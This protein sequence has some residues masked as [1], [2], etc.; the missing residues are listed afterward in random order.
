[1]TTENPPHPPF[2]NAVDGAAPRERV[3][4]YNA[5]QLRLDTWNHLQVTCNWLREFARTGRQYDEPRALVAADLDTLRSLEAYWAFPGW[6]VVEE[7]TRLYERRDYEGLARNVTEVARLLVGDAYRSRGIAMN[8]RHHGS[9]E[10]DAREERSGKVRPY[11]EV[12]VVDTV[13]EED[14]ADLRDNL[15]GV[16]AEDDDF[17]YDIVTV[18][19]VEDAII[20]V[21]FNR[22]IQTCVMRYNYGYDS[23]NRHELFEPYLMKLEGLGLDELYGLP[24]SIA[25]GRL[26]KH[27]RPEV[28]LFLVTDTPLEEVAGRLGSEFRR[29]FY[30]LDQYHELHLSILR[31]IQARYEAPFFDALRRF[32]QKPAGVFHALPVAR[33]K[34]MTNSHWARDLL[35]FYGRGIF[36]A[37]TS[38]T[39]GG[40]DSLLQPRGPIK[41]AQTAAARAFG[42]HE[43]FFVTNGT[44][45][46]NKIVV[47]SLD[48]PGDN[49]Q[50]HPDRHKPHHDPPIL[51]HALPV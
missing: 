2:G 23:T 26:I 14:R 48:Q 15:H 37:E 31:G 44:S 43:T 47:H 1:M 16:R 20:A 5:T 4:Q 9:T 27:L 10:P 46:A 32:S 25:L 22:T 40:L 39:S 8:Q 30:R 38:A 17:T 36:L 51:F 50:I 13:D 11:F 19:S 42:S 45:T 12:L 41:K 3:R 24:R 34:S 18:P 28:D 49:R 7:M 33:G 35:D 6:D 21:L 29:A